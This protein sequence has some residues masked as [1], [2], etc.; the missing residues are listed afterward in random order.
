MTNAEEKSWNVFARLGLTLICA[1]ASG[2]LLATAGY[3]IAIWLSPVQAEIRDGKILEPIPAAQV[4]VASII[5]I[6]AAAAVLTFMTR[7]FVLRTGKL[8]D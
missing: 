1:C 4:F 7:N 3:F 8:T 5:G 6:I 2:A